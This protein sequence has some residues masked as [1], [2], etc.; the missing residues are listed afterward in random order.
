MGRRILVLHGPNLNL[1]GQR[2]ASIYG[3]TSLEE[4]N[5]LIK[6]E[7]DK[8]GLEVTTF[9]SNYEG[10]LVEAIQDARGKYDLIIINPAAYTHTSI[11]LRDAI[12]AV[13]IPVIEVHISNIYKRE[14]FRQKS[15]IAGVAVGQ[16]C[17]FGINS[18]LLAIRA[19]AKIIQGEK[20]V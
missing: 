15:Y 8:L 12:L 7:A 6:E 11:A 4:I 10:R 17:G 3:S 9:Q 13:D 16:I 2:E 19:A 18:Y 20:G 1:L 14:A 5:R